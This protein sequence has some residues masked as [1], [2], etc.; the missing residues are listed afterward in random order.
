MYHV[1][2]TKEGTNRRKQLLQTF[3]LISRPHSFLIELITTV[4]IKT[5]VS[6]TKKVHGQKSRSEKAS[7][8]R[9][10][11]ISV[12]CWCDQRAVRLCMM[13]ESHCSSCET[14]CCQNNASGLLMNYLMIKL[15]SELEGTVCVLSAASDSCSCSA[16]TQ[17]IAAA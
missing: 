1:I 17:H 5:F 9:V 10:C 11:Y 7:D 14:R 15:L 2:V 6:V 12:C 8:A 13:P 16:Q 4:K 3:T